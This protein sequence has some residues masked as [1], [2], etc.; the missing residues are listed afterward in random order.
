M[1]ASGQQSIVP[2]FYGNWASVAPR[3]RTRARHP[4]WAMT[5]VA[6]PVLVHVMGLYRQTHPIHIL[7]W[8]VKAW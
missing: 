5:A 2:L 4:P 1:T 7:V 3:A 8:M 6:A